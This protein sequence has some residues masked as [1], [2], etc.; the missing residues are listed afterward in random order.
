M[1]IADK[2]GSAATGK[3]L[4]QNNSIGQFERGADKF[5]HIFICI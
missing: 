1:K 2:L 3:E 5:F 4:P